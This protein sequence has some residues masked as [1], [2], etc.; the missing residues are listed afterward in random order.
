LEAQNEAKRREEVV[1]KGEVEAAEK[2]R[3]NKRE[4]EEEKEEVTLN[5]NRAL[6]DA[7]DKRKALETKGER[8][9]ESSLCN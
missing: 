1:K 7:Q 4:L 2:D 6:K 9:E 5:L 8:K 3:L